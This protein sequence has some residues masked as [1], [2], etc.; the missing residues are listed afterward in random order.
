MT[1][2]E[3]KQI[4]LD[5]FEELLPRVKSGDR[6]DFIAALLTEFTEQG[7]DI[8]EDFED[9]LADLEGVDDDSED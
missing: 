8:E 6:A 1:R 4:C 3:A 5:V 7:L 9:E 2:T